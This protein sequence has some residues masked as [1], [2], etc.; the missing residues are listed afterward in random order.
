[1]TAVERRAMIDKYAAGYDEVARSLEGFPQERLKD[2]PIP[3]KW[4]AWEIVHHLADSETISGTRVRRLI[5]E[6]R[7]AI[8]GYDQDEYARVLHYNERD[9]APAME[10]FRA[11]RA[12]TTALL[13]LM[14]DAEWKREGWHSEHGVYTPEVWLESYAAHA[15]GHAEQI[16]RLREAV[17]KA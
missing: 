8:V 11:T 17:A 14:S 6:Q 16:R 3:G 9:L 10:L 13:R 1:M 7:P 2:H 4:S 12:A 15:H 5:A